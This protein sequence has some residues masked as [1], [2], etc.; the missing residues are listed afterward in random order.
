MAVAAEKIGLT[1]QEVPAKQ[2][3][4]IRLVSLCICAKPGPPC[5][6]D[7]IRAQRTLPALTKLLAPPKPAREAVAQC[8]GCCPNAAARSG[9]QHFGKIGATSVAEPTQVAHPG[10]QRRGSRRAG[11]RRRRRQCL[12]CKCWVSLARTTQ[13]PW[14]QA[15]VVLAMSQQAQAPRSRRA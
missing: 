11:G 15:D 2:N 1:R 14:R 5:N 9:W 13:P 6:V 3:T 12:P 8:T 4:E 7:D 10:S